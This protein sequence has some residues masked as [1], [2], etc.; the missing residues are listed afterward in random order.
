MWGVFPDG[1][2]LLLRDFIIEKSGSDTIARIVVY[3][4]NI[5]YEYGC[6]VY[7]KKVYCIYE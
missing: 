3:I 6:A 1:D 5:A 2:P 7:E 4:A